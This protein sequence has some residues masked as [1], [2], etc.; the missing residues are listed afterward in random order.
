[1]AGGH[2]SSYEGREEAPVGVGAQWQRGQVACNGNQSTRTRASLW[3]R[4][5]MFFS[6]PR[7][8][9][10]VARVWLQQVQTDHALETAR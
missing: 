4:G 5:E 10:G 3:R 6:N 9:A 8:A 1:M 7:L 2:L